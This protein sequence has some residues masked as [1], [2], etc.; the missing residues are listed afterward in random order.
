MGEN[1]NRSS[2]K[3]YSYE[4]LMI[5]AASRELRDREVVLVGIGIPQLGAILA[6]KTH[7]PNLNVMY[8]S[9]LIGTLPTR[10]TLSIGDPNLASRAC[11]IMN[12]YETFTFLQRG[13][14]DVGFVGAA[15]VDKFGNIN[16]TV[17]GDY[18]RP[19]VRLPGC[20][21]ACDITGLAKRTII[22]T[23]H[24][25]RRMVKK[26]DFLTS[27][28]FLDGAGARERFGFGGGP[29][30]VIT[31]MGILRFDDKTKE[32]YLSSYHPGLSVEQVKLE[33][34]WDLKVSPNVTQ[35]DPPTVAEVEILRNLDPEGRFLGKGH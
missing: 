4:E 20:G 32:M 21:G 3:D 1:V 30:A 19:S 14:I 24:E 26:L 31:T 27:P 9:G 6:Q 35:T 15:Q 33:T 18:S 11:E 28:G 23:P 34:G 12:F 17:I 22:I 16:T 25:K 7:A 29:S 10:L 5:T 8:E 2:A 13:F